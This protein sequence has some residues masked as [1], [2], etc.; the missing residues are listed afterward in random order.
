[1]TTPH[2]LSG[3]EL[4]SRLSYALWSSMPDETLFSLAGSGE[5]LKTE[6]LHAQVDRMLSLPGAEMLIK[7][8]AAQ[9]LGIDRLGE[10]AVSPTVFPEWSPALASSA[11]REMEL[12]FSEFLHEDIPFNEFLTADFNFV[13]AALA[14]HYGMTPPSQEGFSRVVDTN[15]QRRGLIGL[16][17]FLTHTSRETRTSPIIRGTWI[18]DAFMCLTL[19]L[20]PD[21]VVEPLPEPAEGDAPTTVRELIAAHRAAPACS[22]CH[23]LIDPIG[24]ALEHFDGIGR[25]R[26]QYSNGLPIDASGV[27]P[28]GATVD[29]LLALTGELAQNPAFLSCA[30]TKLNTFSLGRTVTD[31]A[32]VAEIVQKWTASAPTLRNLIK[33]TVTHVTFTSRRAVAP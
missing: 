29:G 14:K 6:I 27:L 30:A 23:N 20:P 28:T 21:L 24:L 33:E 4:A 13:D 5:L 26:T 18:L 25:Y 16:A 11:Q 3:Y 17:G 31:P 10:H 9:W 8:F 1:D 15:D 22:G 12:Y 32:A 2:P 7:N 19:H